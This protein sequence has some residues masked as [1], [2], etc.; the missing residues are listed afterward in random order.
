MKKI[1]LFSV[2]FFL[3]AIS[4]FAQTTVNTL[5]EAKA[6]AMKENKNIAVEFYADWCGYCKKFEKKTL[7]DTTVSQKL[8]DFVWVK[9]NAEKSNEDF[10][11]KFNTKSY[12]QFFILNS[13]GEILKKDKG[14]MN[15]TE[16][17]EFLNLNN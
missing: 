9:I 13:K 6:L 11:K 7:S 5:E 10:V 8:Q 12:P 4:A 17:K 16:F 1:K 2:L 14:V 3:V 15:A